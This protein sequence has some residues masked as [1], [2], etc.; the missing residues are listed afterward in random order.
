MK[1]FIEDP[2]FTVIEF[3]EEDILSGSNEFPISPK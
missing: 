1:E 2:D 3:E